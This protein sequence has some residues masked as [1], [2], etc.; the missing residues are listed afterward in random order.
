VDKVTPLL[1]VNDLRIGFDLPE[2]RLIAADGV[3]FQIRRGSTVAL[4][5]ESGSGKSVV[6]QAIM[7]LLPRPARILGGAIL[8]ADPEKPG[9]ITDIVRLP[10]DGREM[11]ALRGGRISII[12]QEPMTSLSPLHTVGNQIREALELHR[13]VSAGEATELTRDMLRMV[14]FPDPERALKTYPFE[15]SGGLRQR[16][17]ISMALVCHPALLIADEPTTALDV[18]IQA[19][20]L[21][22]IK[23]LQSEL[24]MAMLMIT[25]DLGVVANVAEEVVVMY[26]GRIMESGDVDDIF[27]RAQHPYLK[28]LM[29]A[30]PRFDMKPGE[31][32]KPLRE[33]TAHTGHLLADR[34]P[35]VPLDGAPMLKVDGLT[36]RYTIRKG[37]WFASTRQ[38]VKALDDVSFTVEAGECLGLVGE[39]GCGKT[40]LSKVI[41]RALTPDA[42]AVTFTDESGP[43]D[44]LAL[45]GDDLIG[46]RQKL[47]FVFQDPFSSLNPRMT[48]FDIIAEPLVIHRI[49][50]AAW[51]R[52]MVAELMRL[53]GLDVR[54][55]NR[56]PHSFSGG[57]RQR[58]GIARALALRPRM[59]ICDEPVSALDVSIQA[60]VL[61]LL[62]DLKEKLGLTYLF[63]SHNLAVVDYVA[64][65]IAV[66]CAGRIVELAPREALFRDPVHP[67]TQALL[68]AVPDPDLDNP[69]DFGRV[70]DG[71]ASVPSAW[72]EPFTVDAGHDPGFV[73]LGDGHFVRA[74]PK[75]L[76]LRLAS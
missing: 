69:L 23:D 35:T 66:M 75:I 74:D 1:R 53:V 12:F 43:T 34:A 6:S 29:G 68:A 45:K 40:T 67:Y 33:I 76:S 70:M 14:G 19:Q 56:Y 3:S 44:V 54:H 37:G 64:D 32:L 46:F 15:L 55:L 61:N 28:A 59:L 22:L 25:H 27:R 7:G 17:M 41:M 18:T 38:Q 30:V 11:R 5:G 26:R 10:V 36:K 8:F 60:Q 51:R 21:K 47:Q 52:E 2:G 57:Q 4:V 50:D 13:A 73:N 42:G 63:I 16:A 65:R 9:T 39:S 71:R 24:N 49:G 31:R 58:I 20:I 72:P 62:K 48:V